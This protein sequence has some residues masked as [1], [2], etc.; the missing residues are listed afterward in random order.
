MKKEV[1]LILLKKL[2]EINEDYQENK[3][4]RK[5]A[6]QKFQDFF[7]AKYSHLYF[8]QNT[9]SMIK[10]MFREHLQ[11][12]YHRTNE[13]IKKAY[14]LESFKD[15]EIKKEMLTFFEKR[16]DPEYPKNLVIEENYNLE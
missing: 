6:K 15:S 14:P 1:E 10:K 4:N 12:I 5:E 2:K 3:I 8:Q 7:R 16:K 13:E 9:N 11:H